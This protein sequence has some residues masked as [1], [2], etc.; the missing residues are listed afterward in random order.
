MQRRPQPF[1]LPPR[2]LPLRLFSEQERPASDRRSAHAL[3]LLRLRKC[4]QHER[5][6]ASSQLGDNEWDLVGHEARDESHIPR[7]T[8]EFGHDQWGFRLSGSG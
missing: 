3:S 5:V 2:P 8:A 1:G 6:G 7:K 4:V